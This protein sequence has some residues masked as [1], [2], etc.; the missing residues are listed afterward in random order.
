MVKAATK[1]PVSIEGRRAGSGGGEAAAASS[2]GPSGARGQLR[3]GTGAE[4]SGSEG[5]RRALEPEAGPAGASGS[6]RAGAGDRG[7]AARDELTRIGDWGAR[8]ELRA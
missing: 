8:D 6:A 5:P 7:R 2:P 4:G 3:R 1:Q